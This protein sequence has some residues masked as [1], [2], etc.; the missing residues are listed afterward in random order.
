VTWTD[1]QIG[2]EIGGFR[3][4]AV[5]GRGGMGTVYR[6]SQLRLNRPVAF[7]VLPPSPSAKARRRLDR[8]LRE[9]HIAASL[10]HPNIVQIYDAGEHEGLFFIAMELVEGR[11]LH[12]IVAKEGPVTESE[13]VPLFLQCAAAHCRNSGTA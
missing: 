1:P 8:F 6:A 7:K 2:I 5:I 3:L 13:A 11:T 10:N 4:E 9:A 12:E